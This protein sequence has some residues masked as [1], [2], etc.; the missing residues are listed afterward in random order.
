MNKVSNLAISRLWGIYH[1]MWTWS[2]VL[3]MANHL[4]QEESSVKKLLCHL[5]LEAF[6]THCNRK[7][8]C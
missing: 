6:C 3:Y 5:T 2:R 8:V 7:N 4:L 1:V